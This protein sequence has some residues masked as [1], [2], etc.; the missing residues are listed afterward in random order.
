MECHISMHYRIHLHWSFDYNHGAQKPD[1]AND[2]ITLLQGYQ[3]KTQ[4]VEAGQ[5]KHTY[6]ILPNFWRG[7]SGRN[8]PGDS[9]S[10]GSAVIQRH[11][12]CDKLWCYNVQYKNFTSGE[13][14][15]LQF[16]CNDECY[17][18]LTGNW[19]ATVTNSG[20]D[21]YANIELKGEIKNN[22]QISLCFNRTEITIGM[23]NDA[24]PLT[25]N[26]GLYD[27]IPAIAESL[28]TKGSAVEISLLDDLEQLRPKCQIGYLDS[29]Q[30]PIPLDGYY[31]YGTGL[32]PSYWWVDESKNV[33]IVSTVFETLVLDEYSGS[34]T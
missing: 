5:I 4:D 25:C 9:L 10:I 27:V 14:A 17:R 26:W 6:R 11:K 23:E 13:N 21:I 29:I 24:L 15:L 20:Q 32:L 19:K 7:Y 22:E 18:T 33:V 16:Q 34:S 1:F 3:T 28:R 12:K 31:L 8:R 2:L 30:D